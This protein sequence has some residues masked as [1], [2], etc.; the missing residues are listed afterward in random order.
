MK[1]RVLIISSIILLFAMAGGAAFKVSSTEAA[2][3]Y[4]DVE[5]FPASYQ[6][7]L[8]K[9]KEAHP[10][11]IFEMFNTGLEWSDVVYNQTNPAN[12][13]LI[14]SYFDSSL[15]GEYYGDGWSCAT[16]LA[17]EYYLDPRNWLTE[18]YIFQ[19][20]KLTYNGNTQGIATVQKVLANTFM[21]GYIEGYESMGLTYAQAFRDIGTSLG[22]SPV[23]LA[24]RVKQ[25]Q[26][27]YGTS[28]LISGTYPGYE[29]Y[30]NYYNIQATGVTHEQIVKNGLTEAMAEGWNNRYSA[31][32]G[33]S[34]KLAQRYILRGQDTLYLQKFDV[35][36][37]YDGLYW[38][39][40][41]QNVCAP[42]NEGNSVKTAY[43]KAGMLDEAF[44]F[45][46]PVYN[47]MPGNTLTA[48]VTKLKW[49][50]GDSG[51]PKIY[52]DGKLL[53]NS[54]LTWSSSDASVAT[55]D[56]NGS[57]TAVGY[58]T[59]TIS[60]ERIG[61]EPA[62]ITVIVQDTVTLNAS[63]AERYVGMSF[64]L[65]GYVNGEKVDASELIWT[66]SD[67]ETATVSA[68]GKVKVL[69]AGNC[70]ISAT[71]ENGTVA[72]L[73]LTVKDKDVITLNVTKRNWDVG[74]KGK[75]TAFINGVKADGNSLIWTST[76]PDVVT[77][78]PDGVIEAVGPGTGM[79]IC[80]GTNMTEAFC[81][82]NVAGELTLS[83]GSI[84]I[85]V[86]ADEQLELVGGISGAA[87]T[88]TSTDEGVATVDNTGR[89]TA[90]GTG[91]CVI[92]VTAA[93]GES[94]ECTV[95]VREPDI[96]T[97][98]VT[99]RN[100]NIGTK[101]KLTA[102]VNGV[103][104]NGNTMEWTSSDPSVVTVT[105]DGAVEAV[106]VGTCIITST[107]KG[108]TEAVC[109]MNITG[110]FLDQTNIELL[111]GQEQQLTASDNLG[112]ADGTGLVWSSSDRSVAEVTESGMVRG[113]GVG[114]CIIR[115]E[116]A[117][118]DFAECQVTVRED[119]INNTV[120]LNVTSRNWTVG[121][122]ARLTAYVNGE[123]AAGSSMIWNSSDPSVVTVTPEGVVEAVGA[124]TCIITCTREGASTA[125]C[126][127]NISEVMQQPDTVTLN[128]T[129]RNWAVGTMAKLTAYVNGEKAENGT[130]TWSSSDSSVVTVTPEGVVEAVGAGT[131]IIYC[132]RTNATTAE[133]I[134][135]ISE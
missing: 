1:K 42:S 92:T 135:I 71:K 56:K 41:M 118:N 40:Y 111:T 17:V 84:S 99:K 26:G 123:Q 119:V 110:I 44:V 10:N 30:Y 34:Q 51:T 6:A 97:L 53:V 100:W 35:D 114:T 132:T 72:Q 18:D 109:V 15:A 13:S 120:T 70:I 5:Q 23:H 3:Y 21:S 46:I 55:V 76:N 8:Y 106:G 89:V 102:Y 108:A 90:A 68:A 57:I 31:L 93:T 63:R 4:A 121:T 73:E 50:V 94:A 78:T 27:I 79:V 29:G 12:R 43:Q 62:V 65:L 59:C 47:N 61:Y 86:G 77:V 131:C 81:T 9:L 28:D 91:T 25:E 101:A 14:P 128:V 85:S 58:G 7:A 38:H 113:V 75:L 122:R 22:V 98:N 134:M 52:S 83:P 19:F 36:G 54:T 103:K 16:Q 11:W 69:K 87:Y 2:P 125:E 116:K 48:N 130:M 95:T 112:P 117:P 107:R 80:S 82:V 24:A 104:V 127:M 33:G 64:P 133:C 88:W 129:K 126:R 66:S 74:T 105:E 20:E 60:G 124:G 45:K 96:V 39:Q 67:P 115:A 32:L 37:S 49:K